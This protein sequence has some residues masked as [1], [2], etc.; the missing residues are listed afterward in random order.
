MRGVIQNTARKQQINDFSEIRFGN[1]TPTDMDGIIEYKNKAYIFFE[2]K[3]LDTLLPKG[4]RLCMERLVQDVSH[5]GKKAIAAV[6]EHDIHNT[7]I[8]VPSS[9]CRVREIFIGGESKW[10]QIKNYIS[11]MD[12][13]K[14]FIDSVD[15][16]ENARKIG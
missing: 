13:F 7:A 2:I 4:Q 5:K 12:L 16:A 15:G 8:S 9:R 14:R 6:I 11:A 1:I 10:R 3:Y